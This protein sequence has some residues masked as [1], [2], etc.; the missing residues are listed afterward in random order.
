MHPFWSGGGISPNHDTIHASHASFVCFEWAHSTGGAPVQT[1][2]RRSPSPHGTCSLASRW[3]GTPAPAWRPMPSLDDDNC[4]RCLWQGPTPSQ[5]RWEPVHSPQSRSALC[6]CFRSHFLAGAQLGWDL[7]NK[8]QLA[9]LGS[10][11][12]A[13]IRSESSTPSWN[14][15]VWLRDNRSRCALLPGGGGRLG[16]ST[17]TPIPGASWQV[18]P[19]PL[20]LTMFGSPVKISDMFLR[21]VK[22]IRT[23]RSSRRPGDCLGRS[24]AVQGRSLGEFASP[25]AGSQRWTKPI[26]VPRPP[27]RV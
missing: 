17:T 16:P 3:R 26:F 9:A 4:D 1:P 7:A 10:F 25:P 21:L 5:L 22:S 19:P 20:Q 13:L 23:V 15:L 6:L 12:T 27:H 18:F 2:T 24:G 11:A 14:C 8:T